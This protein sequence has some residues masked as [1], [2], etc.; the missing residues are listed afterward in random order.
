MS[1]LFSLTSACPMV[2]VVVVFPHWGDRDWDL[3]L[4][5]ILL[6]VGFDPHSKTDLGF[7]MSRVLFFEECYHLYASS[8]ARM[9]KLFQWVI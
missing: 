4:G 6:T 7:E 5:R 8:G 2:V 3:F 1:E 9:E